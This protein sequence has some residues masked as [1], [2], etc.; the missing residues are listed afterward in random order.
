MFRAVTSGLTFAYCICL[1]VVR[2]VTSGFTFGNND[3]DYCIR[4]AVREIGVVHESCAA[5]RLMLK[6][7]PSSYFSVLL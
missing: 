7:F 2:A 5:A 4:Q 1:T 3:L 6:F